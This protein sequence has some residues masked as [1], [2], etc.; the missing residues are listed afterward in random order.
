MKIALTVNGELVRADVEPRLHLGD[1]LR[2]HLSLTGTHL[3]CGS[4][5]HWLGP[6]WC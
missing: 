6:V 4:T 2:E 5:G 1:F 3:G